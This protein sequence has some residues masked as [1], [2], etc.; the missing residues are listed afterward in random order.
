M[1]DPK[2]SVWRKWDLHIH[3]PD[4]LVQHYGGVAAWAKFIEALSKLP[5]EI[6]VLGISD[7]IFLDGYRKLLAAKNAGHLP[8]IDLLLPV[9]EL[10]LDKF[11]G[12]E[13]GLSRLNYH[14]IFSN[15]VCADV[16]ESQFLNALCSKY[17][18]TPECDSLRISG[19]WAAVPT[20]K[21]LEDLG[22]LIIDSA[23]AEKRSQF[24]AA[25]LTGFNNLCINLNS[26]QEVLGSP[27]FSG[28][29][30]TAVGKNEW[31]NI[32]WNDQAIADKKTIIN[33]ADFVFVSAAS[34]ADC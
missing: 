9:I 29:T 1:N 6:K 7:Y 8:N 23:P 32:K 33:T 28:K 26:V 20:R 30:L 16:I 13:G 18:L 27:Y 17:V 12:S 21:S 10:R 31:A 19:K 22:N 25:L 34:P 14:V 2:G 15:E 4:S 24:P 3:T 11:G 5:P